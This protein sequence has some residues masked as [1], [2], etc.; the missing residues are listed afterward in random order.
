MK[1]TQDRGG[2]CWWM[3][4]L[5]GGAPLCQGALVIRCREK[6]L[7]ASL[8][9]TWCYRRVALFL[10]GGRRGNPLLTVLYVPGETLGPRVRVAAPCRRCFLS[11]RG[12][13]AQGASGCSD[14]GGRSWRGRTGGELSLSCH[15]ALAFIFFFGH[16]SAV[17]PAFSLSHLFVWFDSIVSV[18]L[19]Y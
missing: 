17:A 13:W 4:M 10:P 7:S 3:A 19:L 14:R 11:Y 9:M 15:F 5:G 12:C 1:M 16:V 8:T 18:W 6:S 2:A